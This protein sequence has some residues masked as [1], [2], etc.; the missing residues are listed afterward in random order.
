MTKRQNTTIIDPAVL[1][2]LSDDKQRTRQ[3]TMTPAQR[4]RAT[5][6][7]LRKSVTY[8]LNPDLVVIVRQLA[9]AL[10]IS[11]AGAVDRLLLDALQRYANGDIDFH[12]HLAPSRSARYGWVIKINPNGLHAAVARRL[13]ADQ[14]N[15]DGENS[16]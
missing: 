2:I 14:P 11:P 12:D 7:Q 10:D 13:A 6:R 1:A 9:E 5:K 15:T 8:M 3:R 4:R 16:Q